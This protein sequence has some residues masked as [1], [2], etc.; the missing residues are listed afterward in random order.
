MPTAPPAPAARARATFALELAARDPADSGRAWAYRVLRDNIIHLRLEPGRP[1]SE[2]DV[3]AALR[4][5]HT[6]VREAFIRLA[7]EGLLDVHAQKGTF[8]SRID[9][10]RADEARFLRSVVEKAI[11][12]EA[13]RA[14]P[15]PLRFELSANLELQRFCRKERSYERMFHLDNEFHRILYRGCGKERLWLHIKKFDCDLDRLRVLRLSSR[16]CWDDVIDGHGRIVRFVAGKSPG[17]ADAIVEEH[18]TGALYE[19]LVRQYPGYF[20]S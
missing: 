2:S 14:F 5:S 10:D 11:L 20:K 18:L 17:R 19:G 8:V 6:P 1:V 15:A 3:A 16:L 7:G 12:R 4:V 13:A 9:R